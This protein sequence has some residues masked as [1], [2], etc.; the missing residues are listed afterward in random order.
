MAPEPDRRASAI[1]VWPL[2]LNWRAS[3]IL[4]WPLSLNWRASA[5]LVWPLRLNWRAPFASASLLSRDSPAWTAVE[6]VA[7]AGRLGCVVIAFTETPS[8]SS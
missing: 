6:P 4:V 8:Q 2:S 5:I 3:A 1:L 7:S